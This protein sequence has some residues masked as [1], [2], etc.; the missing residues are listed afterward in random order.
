MGSSGF[1]CILVE[2][3]KRKR[4]NK[5]V[6]KKKKFDDNNLVR[7]REAI[8]DK[9][10]AYGIAAALEFISSDTFPSSDLDKTESVEQLLLTKFRG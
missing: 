4:L 2:I 8:A 6:F 5:D 9:C 3:M 10:R 1:H 7:V